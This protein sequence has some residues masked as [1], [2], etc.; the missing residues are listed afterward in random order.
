MYLDEIVDAAILIGVTD[1]GVITHN[2]EKWCICYL[3]ADNKSSMVTTG[4][5]LLWWI[6]DDMVGTWI[7]GWHFTTVI[8][9]YGNTSQFTFLFFFKY[10]LAITY[11]LSCV[12]HLSEAFYFSLN[13]K[14]VFYSCS[15]LL[16]LITASELCWKKQWKFEVMRTHPK[17]HW[18]HLLQ[19]H[20]SQTLIKPILYPMR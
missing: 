9:Q 13:L 20:S 15:R 7:I 5:W 16:H 17:A 1:K 10:C 4:L 2:E 14:R 3:F 19:I 12:F 18:H 8:I 6:L 11:T